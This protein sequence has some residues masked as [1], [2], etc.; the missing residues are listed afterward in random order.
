MQLYFFDTETT[1]LENDD[2]IIQFAGKTNSDPKDFCYMEYF[3]TEKEINLMA[4][5]THHIT[6]E[7]LNGKRNFKAF[8]PELNEIINDNVLVAH[9]APFDIKMI[10]REGADKPK[11]VIDTN[12]VAQSLL[13][14]N[15]KE[16]EQYKMQYLRYFLGIKLD[17]DVMA[18]D[19]AGDVYVLEAIFW[20]LFKRVKG[21]NDKDKITKMI[22]ISNTPLLL[23]RFSFGKHKGAEMKDVPTSYFR[24]CTDTIKDLSEDLFYTINTELNKR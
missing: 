2:R 9:N 3:K 24:W 18:H 11:F 22:N 20:E 12:K 23:R 6:P 15:E 7:I 10:E 13:Q 4:M 8:L 16:P 5:A 21:E 17:V 19:A 14:Y 1:G